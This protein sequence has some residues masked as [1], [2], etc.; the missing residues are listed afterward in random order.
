[1]VGPEEINHSAW[2]LCKAEERRNLKNS[3]RFERCLA[4]RREELTKGFPEA[5]SVIGLYYSPSSRSFVRNT[6]G[7][8][9]VAQSC[10]LCNKF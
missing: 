1:M 7:R 8:G 5:L 4:V 3:D 6:E 2:I 9:V 10:S